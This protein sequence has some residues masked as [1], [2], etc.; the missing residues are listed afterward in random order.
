MY[1]YFCSNRNI[2]AMTRE[3]GWMARLTRTLFL[4]VVVG[5]FGTAI[6]GCERGYNHGP[7]FSIFFTRKT[8]MSEVL[9]E[10]TRIARESGYMYRDGG[11]S[12][13]AATDYPVHLFQKTD[14]LYMLFSN[15]LTRSECYRVDFFGVID[16]KF[17]PRRAKST[18]KDYVA[19]FQQSGVAAE[20]FADSFCTKRCYRHADGSVDTENDWPGRQSVCKHA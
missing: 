14:G 10:V 11:A 12:T 6:A 3:Q 1:S 7:V 20:F 4:T 2:V 17:Q 15:D 19:A 9:N 8:P 16:W 5:L 13:A 18:A